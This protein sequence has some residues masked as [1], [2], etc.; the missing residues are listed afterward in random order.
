MCILQ[1]LTLPDARPAREPRSYDNAPQGNGRFNDR[2]QPRAPRRDVF[3]RPGDSAFDDGWVGDD[4]GGSAW[5]EDTNTSNDFWNNS[6]NDRGSGFG[7]MNDDVWRKRSFGNG[8]SHRNGNGNGYRN[9]DG[10]S[11]R[12]GNGSGYR[13]GN[14]N[15]NGSQR[16]GELPMMGTWDGDEMAG[17]APSANGW[18]ETGSRS[19]D[20]WG[21]GFGGG[22]MDM[23]A[24]AWQR[25]GRGR[26]AAAG[27]DYD[28]GL[29]MG[30]GED[31]GGAGGFGGHGESDAF[32]SDP[33]PA[34]R[35]RGAGPIRASADAD[36]GAGAASTTTTTTR[37]PPPAE[38]A[39][40]A[41]AGDGGGFDAMATFAED[42]MGDVSWSEQYKSVHAESMEEEERAVRSART[43]RSKRSPPKP[44]GDGAVGAPNPNEFVKMMSTLDEDYG[45]ES[46]GWVPEDGAG[47]GAAA[48]AAAAAPAAKPGR[49]SSKAPAAD[50]A[51]EGDAAAPV[52]K[53]P[54]ARRA[55]KAPD[56]GAAPA[57]AGEAPADAAAAPK[58][59]GRKPSKS[60]PPPPQE[61]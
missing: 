17:T 6:N 19:A 32:F 7:G 46:G 39:S 35:R 38:D 34:P 60:A 26:R 22:D 27:G 16:W 51:P 56:V 5:F 13:N 44:S 48:A 36:A 54:R 50:A 14:G 12:T 21:E 2:R 8:S 11:Y 3:A 15:G 52:A 43:A 40:A 25:A 28:L 42:G 55:S 45:F 9:G 31:L 57:A 33:V 23:S 47:D 29:D 10:N 61:A 20:I 49:K 4:R 37:S 53:K 18:E 30:W 58:K 41:P 1:A 24:P 59:R